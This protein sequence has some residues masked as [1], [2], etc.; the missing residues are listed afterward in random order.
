MSGKWHLGDSLHPQ[1]G[2]DYWFAKPK[3]HTHSFCGEEAIWQGKVYTEERYYLDAIT[4][5]AVDFLRQDHGAPF[6]LYV[7]YNGPYG[8]D[9]DT[10]RGH[11]NRHTAHYAD[12]D[13]N[14]FPRES[15][16]PWLVQYRDRMDN[17]TARRSYACAV[18][19]VDDGVGVILDTLAERNIERDTLVVFTADHGLCGGHHGMWG[20]GDHSLPRHMFQENLRVPL[21]L[22]HPA[23]MPAGATVAT[24]TSHYDF[25]PSMT[26]YL[27][28]P[29]GLPPD[30]PKAGRSYAAAL[31][32]EPLDWNEQIV[33][34]E[35]EET[36]TV[37]T[38][39]WKLIL[40]HPD[41]PN[42]LYNLAGDPGERRN[43]FGEPAAAAVRAAL[44]DRLR[45]FFDTHAERQYDTWRGG[46]SK[47]GRA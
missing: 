24:M 23:G 22:R 7:G 25:L 42:E 28:M 31:R 3:G 33:F 47:A 17:P 11:R 27:G 9:G 19:G 1:L 8:L 2:F 6:F 4:D 18:S 38:P 39:E 13:L 35:Y 30:P 43:L 44:S 21:V 29:G 32:G 20:M 41:G 14:C 5:H 40:R 15:T 34:H 10:L 12:K 45:L 36:R 26:E 37:Q 46:R 16:H